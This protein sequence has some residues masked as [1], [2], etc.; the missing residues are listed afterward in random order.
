MFKWLIDW[1]RKLFGQHSSTTTTTT[2]P[3]TT[4][5]TTTTA[6]PSGSEDEFSKAKMH[7]CPQEVSKWAII[8]TLSVKYVQNLI[9]LDVDDATRN[10][11]PRDVSINIHCLLFRN[12]EWHAGPCDAVKPLPSNKEYKCLCVPDGDARTY[13]PKTGEKM[14]IVIT[15]HCRHGEIG[16]ERFRST[17]AWMEGK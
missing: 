15:S 12:G 10:Q 3:A 17:I 9:R 1:I 13:V 5:T 16:Q 7:T 6:L 11:W 8:S 2:T 4:T 14:G